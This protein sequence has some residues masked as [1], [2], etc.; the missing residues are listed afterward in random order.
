M[1]ANNAL[2][3]SIWQIHRDIYHAI[4]SGREAQIESEG[5]MVSYLYEP[6]DYDL[7]A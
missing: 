1:D 5:P 3:L 6:G 4:L 7:S 2:S